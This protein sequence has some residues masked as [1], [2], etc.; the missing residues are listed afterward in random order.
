[1]NHKL[2]P[3]D[4][5]NN[6]DFELIEEVEYSNLKTFIINEIIKKSVLIKFYS[7]F[8]V[9]AIVILV[10]LLSY[11]GYGLYR[12]GKFAAELLT[13]LASV[14]FSFTLLI[15]IHELIH[16]VAF[17]LLGKKDIGFGVQWKKFLFYA[18]SNRQVLNRKEMLFVALA[19]FLTV[20]IL[21]TVS[22]FISKSEIIS[23]S[24]LVIVLLHFFFCGGDFAIISFFNRYKEFDM[25]TFDD[26]KEKRSHYF[27]KRPE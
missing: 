8:Q 15:P 26:R 17:L 3:E 6:D 22:F 12:N 25:Y 7:I 5:L 27:K 1:M 19:P 16:A 4:L 13:I 24:G 11:Y 2:S 10:G 20:L 21:G 18:E 14:L 9:L 23:L